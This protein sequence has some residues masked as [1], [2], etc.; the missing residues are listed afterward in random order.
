MKTKTQLRS[1]TFPAIVAAAILLATAVGCDDG[2][3]TSTDVII[4]EIDVAASPDPVVASASTSSDFQW[5]AAFTL[6]FTETAGAPATI[7]SLSAVV[8]E[9]SGGIE[10]IT[11]GEEV[12]QVNLDSDTNTIPANGSVDVTAEI[13]YTLP[14]GGKE[15]IIDVVVSIVD[16]NGLE[17]GGSLELIVQ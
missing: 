17:V 2:T 16:D 3:A 4:A 13:L 9:A 10:I 15:A 7:N 8:S 6:T 5:I 1:T 11:E 14:G 12:Y